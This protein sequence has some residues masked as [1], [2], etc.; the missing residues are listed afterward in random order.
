M[1]N[2]LS[3]GRPT[4]RTAEHIEPAIQAMRETVRLNVDIPKQEYK[5]LKQ[6]AIDSDTTISAVV[7]AALGQY[8]LT[9]Q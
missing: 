9:Q 2:L 3:A 7:K 4:Q 5:A 1:S 6:L 8:R